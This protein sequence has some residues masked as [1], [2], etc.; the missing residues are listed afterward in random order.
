MYRAY[1]V[2]TM[3]ALCSAWMSTERQP[4]GNRTG[5]RARDNAEQDVCRDMLYDATISQHDSQRGVTAGEALQGLGRPHEGLTK[6]RSLRMS[7]STVEGK[8]VVH[9]DCIPAGALCGSYWPAT[10][11]I[12]EAVPRIIQ[13]I[14]NGWYLLETRGSDRVLHRFPGRILQPGEGRGGPNNGLRRSNLEAALVAAPAH[15]VWN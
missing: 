7:F 4:K 12:V 8:T 15:G 3:C 9:D 14:A 10:I 1:Y 2:Y 13:G 11:G 5:L 6:H